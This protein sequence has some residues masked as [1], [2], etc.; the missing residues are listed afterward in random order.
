MSLTAD[1]FAEF[2]EAVYGFAPFPWQIRLAQRVAAPGGNLAG[3]WPACLALPTG[4]GKTTCVD[5]AIFAMACQAHL[6]PEIRTAPRRIIFVVDRRVIVD[7]AFE[8]ALKL[9]RMLRN[10]L[11][12]K[13]SGILG[14]V[15]RVLREL[16]GGDSLR[17]LLPP[18]M[19]SRPGSSSGKNKKG[20]LLPL[21]CHQLRGGIYR[22]DAWARTPLQPCVIASTVDQIGSRLLFRGYGCTFKSWPI[23]AGLAANDSLIILDE[24]HCATPFMET[25]LAVQRYRRIPSIERVGGPFQFAIMS[26][27]P[28]DGSGEPFRIDQS[29]RDNL[30]LGRRITARKHCQLIPSKAKGRNAQQDLAEELVAHAVGLIN[31]QRQAIVILVN[32]V[33][34]AK[35]CHELLAT[36]KDSAC[37]ESPSFNA[38]AISSLRKIESL[39]SDY[40]VVLMTGRMRP[41]DKTEI[42]ET[43]L[44]RLSANSS[45]DRQ[46]EKP[47]IVIATQC[48]EVGANLDFDGLV[49]ECASFDALRQR[50]GRLNRTGRNVPARGIITICADQV[51]DKYDDPIYGTTLSATWSFL[52]KHAADGEIDFGI[53]P[54]DSLWGSIDTATRERLIPTAVHA[55]VMLRTHLDIWCQTSPEP[56]P[57]PDPAVFL[58]G[59]D[60]GRPEVQVCWRADIPDWG[61]SSSEE[62]TPAI[63]AAVSM[64]PPTSMECLSV[65]LHVFRRWLVTRPNTDDSTVNDELSDAAIGKTVF[66]DESFRPQH[67]AIVWRGTGSELIKSA[68]DLR[69]GQTIVLPATAGGFD[70]FGHLPEATALTVDIGDR[71]FL[72][73]RERASI[74]LH[75]ALL[76][77]WLDGVSADNSARP[78]VGEL[79]EKLTNMDQEPDWDEVLDLI[80]RIAAE[81]PVQPGPHENTDVV[82]GVAAKV[83]KQHWLKSAM[84][85]SR[86]KKYMPMETQTTTA[87]G[88]LR[89]A[90]QMNLRSKKS[91][92]S[93]SD[94]GVELTRGDSFTGDDETDSSTVPT[95]LL[96]HTEGVRQFVNVFAEYSIPLSLRGAFE[97]AAQLHDLGKADRRF[98]SFLFGGNSLKADMH[99]RSPLAKSAGLN[100]I[101]TSY[102]I[103]CDRSGLPKGFRHEMLAVQLAEEFHMLD[104]QDEHRD[105]ILHLI[106]SHHGYAR[107]FAPVVLDANPCELD[108]SWHSSLVDDY[109]AI[110]DISEQS[111][112]DWVPSHRLDSGIGERFWRLVRRYGWWGLAWMESVFILADRRRSEA[113]THLG[114]EEGAVSNPEEFHQE[115]IT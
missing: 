73:A 75:P 83:E 13:S 100:D 52:C 33:P 63:L 10:A 25:L 103:A 90:W 84:T 3:Q 112:R 96:N 44:K 67:T 74:R 30:Y 5:I 76:A 27:T 51:S 60:D 88:R 92:P 86:F 38:K 77:G 72:K 12:D 20:D 70:C 91:I 104:N 94:D 85:A 42:T 46:L 99:S 87:E 6:A 8:H 50:F 39:P 4:A 48:L 62:F 56:Q 109:P 66:D 19:L 102:S 17:D 65:P 115:A 14:E 59:P 54:M 68:R 32:R 7:E 35:Y 9:A 2:F 18:E 97:L 80:K 64:T 11:R 21:T 114:E 41:A 107:P 58:H 69:P 29:D 105:L 43:W 81:L 34:T 16:A 101:R 1:R 53:D 106:G 111:R 98:Q 95:T 37:K 22:D 61:A 89:P 78:L 71:C 79:S 47:V 28:P 55:P 31:D 23:H 26:A 113:E 24:A 40:D 110:A 93:R 45:A 49:S 82:G 36:A 15:A 108:F 57:S